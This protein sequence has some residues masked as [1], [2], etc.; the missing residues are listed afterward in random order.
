MPLPQ[1]VQVAG[2][3]FPA[4]SP[5]TAAPGAGRTVALTFDD[6]SGPFTSQIVAV[7]TRFG[8][9]ATFFDTGLHDSLSPQDAREVLAAGDSIGNHT[10]HHLKNWGLRTYFTRD[11]QR[12]ELTSAN[13]VL[14]PLLGHDPCV[15]RPPGGAFD[16][17]SLALVRSLGMSLVMWTTDTEDWRQPPMLSTPY[18]RTIVRRAEAGIDLEHPIVLMHAGKASQ[19]PE[20]GP[21]VCAPGEVSSFRG[22]TVAALPAIIEFYLAHGFRFVTL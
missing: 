11:Q 18:Q 21:S 10:Y 14:R 8:V 2:C 20:C 7:L 4:A 1:P 3:P 22:N 5:I 16:A 9:H 17:V 15:M 13:A 19:E 6:G 12:L